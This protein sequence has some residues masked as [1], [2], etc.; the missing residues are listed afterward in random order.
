MTITMELPY[1]I[2]A[3]RY[4][5][6]AGHR[7]IPS[8][9]ANKYKAGVRR[10]AYLEGIVAFIG[11]VGVEIT[12]HPKCKKDGTASGTVMD[13]DNAMKVTLDSLQ[14]VAYINDKQIKYLV[15]Q[16]GPPVDDGGLTVNV[17]ELTGPES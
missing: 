14:E 5:R 17:Y 13:I 8:A 16:Y 11:D 10:Q 7:I 3:N 2:S 1:P 15:A 12:L 9:E 4:W 6:R